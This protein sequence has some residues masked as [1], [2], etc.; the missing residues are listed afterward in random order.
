MIFLFYSLYFDIKNTITTTFQGEISSD[1]EKNGDKNDRD[2]MN[3]TK[4]N[5]H[6]YAHIPA[7]NLSLEKV[8]SFSTPT[9]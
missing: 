1:E 2:V 8:P 6:T 9:F 7:I 5:T 4:T 3:V